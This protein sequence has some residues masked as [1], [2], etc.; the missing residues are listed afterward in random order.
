MRRGVEYLMNLNRRF[1]RNIRHNLSFYI[2]AS[3]LTAISVYLLIS[4]Y[5]GVVMIEKG[6]KEIMKAGNVEDAQFTTIL[7]IDS[8]G[9]RRIEETYN[10][11]LEEIHYVDI[12]EDDN[13]LRVFAPTEK[14]NL[15]QILEGEDISKENE[16]LLN[17]DFALAHDLVVGDTL[18]LDGKVYTIKGLAVRPDYLYAQKEL[19]DYYLDKKSFGQVTMSQDAFDKLDH[20]QSYYSIVFHENNSVDVRQYLFDNYSSIS[21]MSADANNR[22]GMVKDIGTQLR[23]MIGMIMPVMFGMV[24]VIIAVV[25]GRM[26]KKE[27]KQIGTLVALGYRKSEMIRHYGVYAVIPGFAGSVMGAALSFLLIQPFCRV[28][29]TDYEMIN[30][31]MRIH[32]PSLLIALFA[33]SVLYLITSILAVGRLLRKNTVLLLA[34]NAF[35][36]QKKKSRFLAKRRMSFR[37]KFQFRAILANKSRTFVVIMGMFIGGF[38]CALGFIMVDS[39]NYLIDTGLDAA[40][41]YQ[42]QYT[43]NTVLTDE[44]EEGETM[45]SALFEVEDRKDLF[46]LSGIVEEPLF[47]DLS[48]FSGEPIKYGSYY[49]TSNAAALYGI[50]AGDEFTFIHTLT[51]KEFTVIIEDIIDDNMQCALYT[52]SGNAQKLLGLPPGS[53]NVIMSDT[54][55]DIDKDLIALESSKEMLRDQFELTIDLIIGFVYMLI[56]FGSILCIISVYLTV[57][58]L[59]E[60]NKNNISML[61][62]L[63]YHTR[64]INSLVLNTNHILLPFSFVVSILACLK[65]C[66]ELFKSFIDALNIYI[67]PVITIPSILI[68]LFVLVASYFLSLQL[69]KRK[70]YRVDMVESLKDN[71]D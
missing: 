37:R 1:K 70:A 16:I 25:I 4:M 22:I 10:T 56:G 42:Y 41:S 58:M 6:F 43:L 68:C 34:G 29:V 40:G 5:S 59:V 27:Q 28:F 13:T 17:R 23:L 9:T 67:K 3:L 8:D 47:F 24:V 2:S 50:E 18:T 26:V 31:D 33:P 46:A 54:A 7:P 60:E 44:P 14:I 12:S 62:V 30:Y 64:E 55:L 49:M 36:D 66:S 65:L 32:W 71:R 48:T 45:L 52:S 53:Y 20:T 57:N 21:F 61:K 39:C 35:G 11:E 51:T 63:G 15:Y 38:V 69:L 19:T